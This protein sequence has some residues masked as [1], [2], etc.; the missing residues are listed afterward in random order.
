MR[1][2]VG[3]SRRSLLIGGLLSSGAGM[4]EAAKTK[5]SIATQTV[6]AANARSV[7]LEVVKATRKP[8]GAIVFS[9]G[10]FSSPAKYRALTEEWGKAGFTVISPLHVDS[11]DHP[12]TKDY[13]QIAVWRTRV[14]DMEL[15][16]AAAKAL[17]P[18]VPILAAGHS[19]GALGALA[20]GGSR[21]ADLE[22][23]QAGSHK[24]AAIKAVI[25]FSPPGFMP[26]FVGTDAHAALNVPT[27]VQTGTK[28]VLPGFIDDYRMH[29]AA[30]ETSPPGSKFGLVLEGVDHYF[31]GII[32][33]PELPGPKQTERFADAVAISAEFARSIISPPASLTLSR[34][35]NKSPAIRL[36]WR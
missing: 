30:F 26:G 1:G 4:A 5:P 3:P 9:H 35:M 11:T 7:A 32:C 8:I 22:T 12:N 20:L 25:A 24:N 27:L 10:A 23:K 6:I 17:K 15:A 21:V 16:I 36:E 28:D 2:F 33:R 34:W 19:Y 14:E 13:S 31:G 29:L 18:V